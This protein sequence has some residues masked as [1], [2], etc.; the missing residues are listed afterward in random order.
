MKMNFR[1][2]FIIIILLLLLSAARSAIEDPNDF[3]G[4][5]QFTNGNNGVGGWRRSSTP[6]SSN[7]V[8]QTLWSMQ[9]SPESKSPNNSPVMS[10]AGTTYLISSISLAAIQKHATIAWSDAFVLTTFRFGPVLSPDQSVL[11][12]AGARVFSFFSAATN[13]YAYDAVSG[14]IIWQLQVP[15]D[16]TSPLSLNPIDNSI[17]FGTSAG[18]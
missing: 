8:Y 2:H 11:Y 7:S 15:G 13:A 4:W 18:T 5:P 9:V 6:C 10:R 3:S 14:A 12:V 17:C 1:L 16:I